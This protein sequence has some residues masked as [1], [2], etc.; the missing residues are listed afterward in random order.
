MKDDLEQLRS[1]QGQTLGTLDMRIDAMVE[2]HTQA[3]MDK[4]E[5][6]QGRNR[7]GSRNIGE[8]SGESNREPRVTSTEHHNRG[9]KN[10]ST[11][12]SG[13]LSSIAKRSNRPRCPTKTRGDSTGN[14]PTSN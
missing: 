3:I 4:L 12:G 10:A 14:R 13:N 1:Q 6:L 11:R 5:G 2:I 7:S 9:R 8:N